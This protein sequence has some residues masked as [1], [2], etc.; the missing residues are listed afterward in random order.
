MTAIL[1]TAAHRANKPALSAASAKEAAPAHATIRTA[2]FGQMVRSKLNMRR[3]GGAAVGELAALIKAFGL[4]QN[5]VGFQ[6]SGDGRAMAPIEIVAGGRRLAAIGQLIAAGDLPE[7]FAIPYLQVTEQEAVA[8][9]LAENLG[10]EPMHPADIVDCMRELVERGA[11]PENIAFSFGV[12][13]LT[14]KRR[15]KLAHVSPRLFAL[16]RNDEICTEQ[17]KAFAVSEDHAAQEQVWDS[18]DPWS[19][20]Q[21]HAIRRLLLAQKIN[22]G[23]DRVAVFVGRPA[24]EKAGGQVA[25]DLFSE[26]ND[27]FV[28]DAFL[29]ERLAL[30]KLE[31]IALPLRENGALW[32]DILVRVEPS[33]LAE[34]GKV[35]QARAAPTEAQAAELAELDGK[36]AAPSVADTADPDEMDEDER[37]DAVAE[38]QQSLAALRARR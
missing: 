37:V 14:V 7:D 10:R 18:L 26:S 3:K 30:A 27:G 6:R 20:K 29:L 11:S 33:V 1:M 36:M 16:Y 25:R 28:E 4:L 15:L 12:D 17:M 34:Y 23:T 22:I 24:Y 21:P 8:L 9:S 32:T 13:A 31:R 2:T 5:L 19:R 38:Q 35:R